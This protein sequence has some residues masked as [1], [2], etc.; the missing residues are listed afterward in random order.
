MNQ[1]IIY[2]YFCLLMLLCYA[3]VLFLTLCL[4]LTV[5]LEY[6]HL[7]NFIVVTVM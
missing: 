4:N 5:L 7:S 6:N 3:S 2:A 1:P